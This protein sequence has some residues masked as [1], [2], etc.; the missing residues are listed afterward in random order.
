MVE[1]QAKPVDNSQAEPHAAVP[2][3]VSGSKL[4]ELAKDILLLI[5]GNAGTTIPYFD[6]QHLTAPATA[7]NDPAPQV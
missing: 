6:A 7:D 3:P 4:K 2:V 1:K 5:L